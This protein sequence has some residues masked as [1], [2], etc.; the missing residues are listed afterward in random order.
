MVDRQQEFIKPGPWKTTETDIKRWS[1]QME[2]FFQKGMVPL[3]TKYKFPTSGEQLVFILIP[4][5]MSMSDLTMI[6]PD[7]KKMT[8]Q[9]D[10]NI[11]YANPSLITEEQAAILKE[12]GAVVKK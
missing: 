5:D 9:K 11:G 12:N 1:E 4:K 6:N 10:N 2:I 7:E 8:F 3:I